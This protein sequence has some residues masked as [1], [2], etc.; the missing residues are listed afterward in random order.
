MSRRFAGFHRM[1]R[2]ACVALACAMM[3]IT[4]TQA[5]SV[6]S[7]MPTHAIVAHGA[8]SAEEQYVVVGT[9]LLRRYWVVPASAM[10]PPPRNIVAQSPEGCVALS[11]RIEP[12]G[13]AH[14]VQII[15]AWWKPMLPVYIQMMDARAV[16]ELRRAH[17]VPSPLNAQRRPVYSY[18]EE[19]Y[20]TQGAYSR[21]PSA[22]TRERMLAKS[23]YLSRMCHVSRF[24]SRV[25]RAVGAPVP[26]TR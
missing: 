9:H 11:V 18:V 1:I 14:Q 4:A 19:D 20:F 10:S 16:D 26:E 25:A 3:G 21:H 24:V 7:A 5:A 2:R 12:D 6:A 23:T 13:T 15:K 22:Y 8:A 17:F